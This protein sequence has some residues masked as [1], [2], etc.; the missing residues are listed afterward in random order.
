[1]SK[2]TYNKNFSNYIQIF[3]KAPILLDDDIDAYVETISDLKEID[4]MPNTASH[5]A[6]GKKGQYNG[7]KFDSKLEFIFYLY[8]LRIKGVPIERNTTEYL[9][10]V[11]EHCKKRKFYPDFKMLGKFYEIKGFYR[12]RDNCKKTQHPEVEFLTQAEM[13]PMI[14]EVYKKFPH[15]EDEYQ[16]RL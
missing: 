11:D 15:W 5:N 16:E 14:E 4:C 7:I 2:K 8:N 12:E 13:K 10:Y 9:D 6:Q 3:H 1:M